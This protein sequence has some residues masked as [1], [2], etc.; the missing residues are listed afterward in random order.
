MGRLQAGTVAAY[1]DYVLITTREQLR[2]SGLHPVAKITL[3]LQANHK[4]LPE[5]VRRRP[6]EKHMD[7]RAGMHRY[8]TRM[9]EQADVDVQGCLVANGRGKPGLHRSGNRVAGE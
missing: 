4:V 9:R 3:G 8:R 7:I 2:K 1:D 5:L 6:G